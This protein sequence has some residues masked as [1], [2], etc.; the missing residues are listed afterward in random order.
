MVNSIRSTL[1][2][3]AAVG[4]SRN[5]SVRTLSMQEGGIR[6]PVPTTNAE[7]IALG[8][9]ELCIFGV[10]VRKLN[11]MK[12]DVGDLKDGEVLYILTDQDEKKMSILGL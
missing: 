1:S 2:A 3:S 6:I 7:L 12:V 5:V 4:A 9:H 8:S 11:Y 10:S